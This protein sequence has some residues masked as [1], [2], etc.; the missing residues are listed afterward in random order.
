M[1]KATEHSSGDS[2]SRKAHTV[3]LLGRSICYPA[4]FLYLISLHQLQLERLSSQVFL[5]SL[6]NTCVASIMGAFAIPIVWAITGLVVRKKNVRVLSSKNTIIFLS[7]T[8]AFMVVFFVTIPSLIE[9]CSSTYPVSHE[10]VFYFL[11]LAM[12]TCFLALTN[13]SS[14]REEPSRQSAFFF[15]ITIIILIISLWVLWTIFEAI[16]ASALT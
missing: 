13:L 4:T 2:I 3:K 15:C 7:K 8:L 11:L 16:A 10:T 9:G 6:K 5:E 12:W 1:N 14:Y